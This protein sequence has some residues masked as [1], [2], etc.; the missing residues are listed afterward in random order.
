MV[1]YNNEPMSAHTT[2]KVGGPVKNFITVDSE[3]DLRE[4][5]KSY[6]D[7]YIIGNGSNLIVSD[8]GYD[9]TVIEL[10]RKFS[11]IKVYADECEIIAQ[12]GASL[13]SLA[14]L[15]KDNELTGLEFAS[16][17]PGTLGGACIMNAGAYDGEMKNVLTII[18]LMDKDGNVT[19]ETPEECELGYRYSNIPERKLTVIGA[20]IKLAKGNRDDI[21]AK[22]K[23]LNQ[24][25][26]DK[27]PLEFPS[28]GSTFKRP[29]GYF[30][31][32]L[33][34]DAGLQGHRVGG[35]E[36]SKKHA[37]FVINVGGGTCADF[38]RLTDEV[39]AKVK[40]EFGVTLEREVKI[41]Q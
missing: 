5:V 37:G 28:A 20:R 17:I 34:Q 31:G 35:M 40:E 3:E 24:R 21:V 41:L 9:G 38:M 18:R 23:E 12:A 2:F 33:I 30:A 11:E 19:E 39:I 16:G 26:L 8:E 36:V 14:A 29:A 7:Y 25:R 27:Q 22:M 15:A 13:A 6:P 32:K 10:G 4:A 1:L